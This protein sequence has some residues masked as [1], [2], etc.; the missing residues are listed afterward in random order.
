MTTRDESDT[1]VT[2]GVS[3]RDFFAG[4]RREAVQQAHY[5]W[6][7]LDAPFLPGDL[8]QGGID[9]PF[10]DA[11]RLDQV[12]RDHSVANG[13]VTPAL[14]PPHRSGIPASCAS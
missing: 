1:T 5:P 10:A 4:P 7:E 6:L 9:P 2:G 11:E 12:R 8:V 3:R 14:P 13:P